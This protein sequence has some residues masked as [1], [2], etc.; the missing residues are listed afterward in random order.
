MHTLPLMRLKQRPSTHSNGLTISKQPPKTM[1][2]YQDSPSPP[3]ISRVDQAYRTPYLA[4]LRDGFS[5]HSQ[6]H[7]LPLERAWISYHVE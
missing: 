3:P 5:S 4:F 6:P 2:V 1:N 7:A